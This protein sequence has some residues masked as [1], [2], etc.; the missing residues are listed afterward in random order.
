M[1]LFL[2]YRFF[3]KRDNTAPVGSINVHFVSYLLDSYIH[4]ACG[5]ESLAHLYPKWAGERMIVLCRFCFSLMNIIQYS[6]FKQAIL[7][8]SEN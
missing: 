5:S 2:A 6:L 1:G 8:I 4:M 7:K 3:D